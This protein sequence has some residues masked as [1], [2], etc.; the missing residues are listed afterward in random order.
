MCRVLVTGSS[1]FIGSA[2]V[3]RLVD[4]KFIT[5]VV[6]AARRSPFVWHAKVRDFK[7]DDLSSCTDWDAA[8]QGVDLVVHCAGRVHVMDDLSENSLH[9]Y[10]K[11][12]VHGTIHLARKAV[13]AGVRRFV[14]VSSIKVNGEA[15]LREMP[16]TADDLPSPTD[17]YGL[18][19]LEAEQ[20]L[21]SLEKQTGLEVVIVRPPLVY[22]PC[23]KAN[24]ANLMRWVSRGIPL[25][26]GAIHNSRSLVSL[27]NLVDL[28][29]VC[30]QHPAAAGQTFLVSD[31]EDV[32]TTE[33]VRLVAQVM[34]K[35][36]ILFP[37]PV[38]LLVW[39]AA[40]LGKRA[41]AQR[42]C[43]SLQV[44]ID[45]TRNLLGWTAPLTMEQGLMKVVKD[46]QR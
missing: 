5:E 17:P 42:L 14:F 46:V 35:K 12:N 2:L 19:K 39:G 32:S 1:G 37:V 7:I 44:D 21:R 16:F 29:V 31:G 43:S 27:S 34:G 28:L 20:E 10:R 4:E 25:P 13:S 38:F 6:A 3:Y 23:V 45:K 24:F 40:L 26:L 8:L 9:A 36:A 18:S 30:L 22:G 33:L 41:V 15:T 11:T